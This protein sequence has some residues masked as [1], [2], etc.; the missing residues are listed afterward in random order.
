MPF[1]QRWYVARKANDGTTMQIYKTKR[2]ALKAVAAILRD[3]TADVEMG[4]MVDTREPVLVGD[5][6]R[7]IAGVTKR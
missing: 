2:L 6:L 7:R 3:P 1:R 5:E 4:P